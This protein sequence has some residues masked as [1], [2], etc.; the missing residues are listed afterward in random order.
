MLSKLLHRSLVP[1]GIDPGLR[2][3]LQSPGIRPGASVAY[4]TWLNSLIEFVEP[5]LTRYQLH[6]AEPGG[7]SCR[8]TLS[9][10][11]VSQPPCR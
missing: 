6:I 2:P 4:P 3:W 1:G 10:L 5:W 9:L 7:L 8:G 11:E